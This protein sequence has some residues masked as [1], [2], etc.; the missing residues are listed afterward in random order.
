MVWLAIPARRGQILA[1]DAHEIVLYREA[2]EAILE[3]G[4]KLRR[5]A[6]AIWQRI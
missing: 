5:H 2:F 1:R 6:I 4:A 3:R